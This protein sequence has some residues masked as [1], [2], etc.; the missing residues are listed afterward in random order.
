MLLR[1]SLDLSSKNIL[2][3]IIIFAV[4]LRILFFIGVAE[5]DSY[6]YSQHAFDISSGQPK[7]SRIDFVYGIR[8]LLTVPLALSFALLGVRDISAVLW[9]FFCSLGSIILIFYLGRLLF[10][11]RT[12]L[13]AA[14]LLS[15][16]P[17]EIL[18]ATEIL[19]DPILNV[20][21]GL[22]LFLFLRSEKDKKGKFGNFYYFLSGFLLGMASLARMTAVVLILFFFAYFVYTRKMKRGYAYL[23]LGIVLVFGLTGLSYYVTTGDF[24][25]NFHI[26]NKTYQGIAERGY[27]RTAPFFYCKG[28]AGLGL[29]GLASLGFFYHFM[30]LGLIFCGRIRK[31]KEI[32]IPLLWFLPIFLFMDLGSSSIV[33]YRPLI[34]DFRFL[35]LV[36]FPVILILAF[37]LREISALSYKKALTRKLIVMVICFLLATSLYGAYRVRKNILADAQP[38]KMAARFLKSQPERD[39]YCVHFR[40]MLFLNYYFK[41]DKGYNFFGTSEENTN[42]LLK[43]V[44]NIKDSGQMRNSY[45]VIDERHVDSDFDL[46]GWRV[47]GREQIPEFIYNLPKEWKILN[48]FGEVTIYLTS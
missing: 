25:H 16:F 41:Y 21:V 4:I 37:S 27:E 32:V 44:Y 45:V 35:S 28:L 19:P 39:I 15:F 43:Y 47:G 26:I 24:L 5:P 36:T 2:F 10:D 8:F 42:S 20:F 29:K 46:R 30:V 23:I 9:P 48:K 12:G 17:Q 40:W 31:F 22:S 6:V 33:K 38:Y 18:L 14:F 11:E 3:L 1:K 34:K 13:L 7:L